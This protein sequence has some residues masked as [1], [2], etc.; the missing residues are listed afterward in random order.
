MP[1]DAS[2]AIDK[3]MDVAIAVELVSRATTR[4]TARVLQQ[5]VYLVNA[6][7][8]TASSL[9]TAKFRQYAFLS[10]L[11]AGAAFCRS[12]QKAELAADR[13]QRL[14]S[15]IG[16][17]GGCFKVVVKAILKRNKSLRPPP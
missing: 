10:I 2:A 16:I 14:P 17:L 8:A 5:V 9:S 12:P 6:P 1:M 4:T 3:S 13:C 11:V 7:L 15:R